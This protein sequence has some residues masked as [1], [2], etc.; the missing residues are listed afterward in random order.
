MSKQK[1]YKRTYSDNISQVIPKV[2][3]EKDFALS[4][5]QRTLYDELINSH[6]KFCLYTR[7]L[8][9]ISATNNF[10][11]IDSIAGL[12]R[13][14]IKQNNLTEITA[15]KLELS[16][17]QP[18]GYDTTNYTTSASFKS[19]LEDTVLPKI[20][21]NS[22][23]LA[24]DTSSAFSTTASGTHE[25][26]I[27]LLGWGYFLNTSGST[28][29]SYSPSSYV[30][31]ALTD[32]Y[33]NNG[34]FDTVK[35]V[36][37]ASHY[38]WNDWAD[39]S[40]LGAGAFTSLLP[41][42]LRPAGGTYTSGTQTRDMLETLVDIV[43]SNQ[44]ADEGDTYVEDAFVDYMD[45]GTLLT[46]EEQAGAFSK[47]IKAFSYS[48]YDTN[49]SVTKLASIFDIEKCPDNLLPYLGDL[50]GWR[51]YGSS[52]DAWRRQLRNAVNLYK[53]KGT[54]EGIYNAMTTVL[55]NTPFQSS[56]IS[57]FYESYVPNLIYY[58]LKTETT[59]FDSF[60]S[61]TQSEGD[62]YAGGNYNPS[63]M[64]INIRYVMDNMLL[65]AVQLFPELFYVKNFKFDTNNPDF[66][67][68]YRGRWIP[69]PPW[70]EEKFY[71]DCDMSE[72][73]AAFFEHELVCLGVSQPVAAS[74]RSFIEDNTIR[75]SIDPKFYNNGFFFLTSSIHQPPNR[76]SIINN[77]EVDKYDYFP[78]WNGKS[79]HFDVDVSSGPFSGTFLLSDEFLKEDFFQSLAVIDEFSPAKSIPRIR[80]NLDASDS[81]VVSE[82]RCPSVRYWMYDLPV[83]GTLG[84]SFVSGVDIRRVPGTMGSSY[85][86][87]ANSGRATVNHT[88][89]PVFTRSFIDKPN[90][91]I[92][93]IGSGTESPPVGDLFRNNLRRRNFSKTL[94]K[95]GLYN[96]TGFNMPSYFNTSGE[97]TDVEYQPLGLL[98]LIFNYHKVINP[99]DLYEVSSFPYN[100]DVWSECWGLDS[101]RT[102]SGIAASSTFPIRGLTDITSGT[103]NDYVA[104]ERT[105][106]FSR[107]LHSFIDSKIDYEAN[108]I[109]KKNKFMLDTSSYLDGSAAI[110]NIL[111]DKYDFTLDDI[112][113]VA[114]GKRVMSRG[115]KDGIHK[116]FLDYLQYFAGHGVGNSTIDTIDNGGLNI[117]SHTFGPLLYNGKFTV[118]GSGT[119]DIGVSSQLLN[120]NLI[121]LQS[122]SVKDLVSLANIT[123][124]APSALPAQVS[125]YRNPYILSGV[126]FV[127]SITG[128][129][130][131]TIVDLDPSTAVRGDDNYLINNNIILTEPDGGLSRLRFSV[132]DYG[133]ATNL[134]IPEH[135]FRVDVNAA[136]GTKDSP[137]LGGGSFGV[138]L[139][140][141][142]E[143]DEQGKSGFWNYMPNGKW[144]YIPSSSVVSGTT[145]IQYVRQNLVHNL[146]YSE[147][148]E[149]SGAACLASTTDKDVLLNME[150]RDFRKTTFHFNTLN[151]PIKTHLSYYQ[152]HNQVHRSDQNYVVELIDLGSTNTKFGIIDYISIVDTREEDRA[153]LKH[154][155]NYNNYAMA[156]ETT[157]DA[158]IFM[159]SEGNIIPSGTTLLADSSGNIE[160]V[161]GSKVTF[162][163]AQA[164]GFAKSKIVLYSQVDLIAPWRWSV[165]ANGTQIFFPDSVH[166]GPFGVDAKKIYPTVSY[167]HTTGDTSPGKIIGNWEY[168]LWFAGVAPEEGDCKPIGA[169]VAGDFQ[170]GTVC[171]PVALNGTGPYKQALAWETE[172]G[173]DISEI[174]EVWHGAT[175]CTPPSDCC[176]G[177]TY[178]SWSTDDPDMVT[179]MPIDGNSNSAFSLDMSV[180][181][182]SSNTFKLI[183]HS[184]DKMKTLEGTISLEASTTGGEGFTLF[185][186]P[187][188]IKGKTKGSNIQQYHEVYIPYTK[189]QVMEVLREFNRLQKD[190]ASRQ[191][192]I[193][194]PKF[195]PLGGSRLNYKV[196][197]MWVQTGG[198]SEYK[199]NNNQYTELRVEN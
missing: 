10:S 139:H 15:R 26:L 147:T 96:R 197:P 125:E 170:V 113:D 109:A 176:A 112:Y 37:G 13:W 31:E 124:T 185:P 46:G 34:T 178:P 79:S 156:K 61:W 159:D 119:V 90:D 82:Y 100:L 35:G 93:L 97:G 32:L 131:F 187:L 56:S 149:V 150:E 72:E 173:Y 162:V 174:C 111:W 41:S 18:L 86:P 94:E 137:L 114:L 171:R 158:F 179:E 116:L 161:G 148:Y 73:L 152:E 66:M 21:L 180:G 103:C 104:R 108:Y 57:E 155:F 138:W 11:D 6:I 133:G 71:K 130:K 129:S 39:L 196:A 106:E 177:T 120:K 165:D 193:S 45:N 49:N 195:G 19:F 14:F 38:I 40:G 105:P 68:S 59:V 22:S 55:P 64:D 121:D 115:S 4:G 194:A 102:M 89:K 99:Y 117:L 198:Y 84:G 172:D 186:S 191:Y 63:Y 184:A 7:N 135:T 1:L 77:F 140:T 30:S 98:N 70:E 53:Q 175:D 190:L 67:F 60:T 36:K 164:Y 9:D 166:T 27:N 110:K 188:T 43:Y 47:L 29:S 168:Q 126:E 75:G 160:T 122:F 157:L 48:F 127:D 81:A 85:T 3:F 134:L 5:N 44:Y 50:I 107:A 87:P 52:P 92:N 141:A 146:D 74:F 123:A 69:I 142:P 20:K 95:G 54:K 143:L 80:I 8:L 16:F 42:L 23:N 144:K 183:A 132:K 33:F 145:A 58:L 2:Y 101:V 17:F 189:E 24:V 25:Y 91:K 169:T 62:M 181:C 192:S 83:S 128:T 118:D 28:T 182:D 12:S 199:D 151:Q 65:R 78:L 136:I 76:D 163:E 154:S 153:K 88:G 167:S 51:L